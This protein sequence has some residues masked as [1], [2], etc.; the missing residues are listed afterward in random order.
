MEINYVGSHS[1]LGGLGGLVVL[2]GEPVVEG[3]HEAV[4]FEV[5]LAR[6]WV[7]NK[8]AVVNS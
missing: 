1:R 3:A 8:L 2:L 4:V 7:T 5:G 6:E